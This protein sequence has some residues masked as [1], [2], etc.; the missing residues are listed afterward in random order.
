[1]KTQRRSGLSRRNFLKMGSAA[2]VTPAI[3]GCGGPEVVAAEGVP[4]SPFNEDSTAEEVTSGLDLS[5]KTAV[6]TGC[7]SGIGFETMRVLAKRGAYVVGTGR[8]LEK[9]QA[10]CVQVDGVTTPVQLEL[11]DFD[12]VVDCGEAI[13]SLNT[14]I[15]LIVCNAGMRGGERE[16]VYGLEK[17]FVVN[18]LGHF[19]LVNRLLDRLYFSEQGRVVVVGSRAAYRDAPEEGI[20]F[21]NLR[22]ARGYNTRRAYAHSKLANALFSLEL[23][24]QLK[25]S[26]ITSNALH[27]GVINTNIVRN[28]SSL[29]RGGF[30]LLTKVT[31]KSLAQGAA[32]SCFVA[33]HPSLRA[34]S[35]EYFEDCN[36]VSV[37]HDGHIH[38]TEMATQ[39]WQ[40]SETLTGDYLVDNSKINRNEF[41]YGRRDESGA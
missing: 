16:T 41:E 25:G 5:G 1:M 10:A 26:R 8:T 24:R 38:D 32:T 6:V 19:I 12:S 23:A 40:V 20:E 21:G 39:L 18:H 4:R 36:A 11:S 29:I 9:A 33:T 17:H 2:A 27:P 34:I 30:A 37:P 14:P 31:G 28:E 3:A 22:G 35:G 7:N 15:D 13:R